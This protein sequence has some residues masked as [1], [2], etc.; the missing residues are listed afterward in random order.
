MS[1]TLEWV[2]RPDHAVHDVDTGTFELARPLHVGRLVEAGLQLHEYGH[3][4]ATFRSADQAA[5]DRAV[6]AGP[7][8]RHLDR[9]HPRVVGGL[10]DERLDAG[11]EALVRMMDEQRTVPHDVED[12]TVR[13]LGG[14]DSAGG[15]GRP[16]L[17]LQIGSL[18]L[19]QL[20]Q[21]AQVDGRSVERDV[22]RCQFE[23][24]DEQ[25]QQ[26]V[27]HVVRDLEADRPLEAAPAQFHL[28]RFEQ[29]VGLFLLER[30][31][32]VAADAERCPLLDDHA[33]E[34]A[35]ELGGDQLLD[36]QE[37]SAAER[38]QT[39]EDARHLESGETAV[40]GFG[41][42][43]VDGERQGEVGDVRE[44][45]SG[46]DGQRGEHGEHP[47]VVERVERDPLGV[48]RVG[49]RDDVDALAAQRRH[50]Q[51][52]ECRIEPLD[53][54]RDHVA[55]RGE[56]LGRRAAVDR[57]AVDAGDDL[58]LQC[59]DADLEELVEVRGG[60]GAELGALQQGD[61]GFG[62]QLEDPF[63][64]RDPAQFPAE[65][66]F[67][68]H[69]HSP[70]YRPDRSARRTPCA[71][72]SCR[73][74]TRRSE[75]VVGTTEIPLDRDQLTFGVA[76]DALTVAAELRVVTGQQHQACQHAGTELVEDLAVAPVA[77]DLPM[78]C[79]RTVVDDSS[80]RSRGLRLG[81]VGHG[82][83]STGSVDPLP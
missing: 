67:I 73:D 71:V 31:V 56:L 1:T 81:N 5:D 79:H 40:A 50:E 52:E 20:P 61:A 66:P 42:G 62:G 63:V 25:A 65:E 48:G 27:A 43:D 47:L 39:G 2:F 7:V 64:E 30:E 34:Q 38:H 76:N 53:E 82:G 77:V 44:R 72:R 4:D 15:D 26:V 36:R 80:V 6:A 21:E 78:G 41:V 49:V 28:D 14:S 69:R 17:V 32:G 46:V 8:E 60:D 11:A 70:A 51:V 9:L 23:L 59:G 22:L 35:V 75:L 37:A 55:D 13:H 57:H 45:V 58:V 54:A 19:E 24:P 68:G 10:G 3:L 12:R 18:D 83:D 16:G 33:D 74:R 29:V